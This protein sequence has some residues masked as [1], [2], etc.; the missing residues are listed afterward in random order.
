MARYPGGL[1]KPLPASSKPMTAFD[2]VCWHTMVGSLAGTDGY[3]RGKAPGVN[4]HLGTGGKGECWQ[5]VDTRYQ[6]GANYLGNHHIISVETADMGPGFA[7]WNTKD[8]NAVPAWT[9]AQMERHVDI[10]VWA[11]YEHK[12]PLQLVP[13]GKPGHRGHAFHRMGVPGYMVAG[14]EKW[15]TAQGKVC[16]GNR[17]IAQI[18]DLLAEA[19]RRVGQ[20]GAVPPAAPATPSVPAGAVLRRGS[21][22]PA[23]TTLQLFM[24]RVFKAYNGYTPNG[25]FGPATEAGVRE[26]QRR[27][28]LPA[29]GVVGP[30]TVAKLRTFGFKG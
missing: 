15:S 8:G 3:F 13:N 5:W 24:T 30:A 1:W 29:D 28:G 4:S 22:G 14:A 12:V 9:D 2:L 26:F 25:T 21:T 18:P 16:P 19:R 10:A 11:F 6:S 27:A 23:V 17:R 20:G 7:A